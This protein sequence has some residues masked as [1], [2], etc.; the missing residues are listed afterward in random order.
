MHLNLLQDIQM[1]LRNTFQLTY[2]T[3]PCASSQGKRPKEQNSEWVFLS[4]PIVNLLIAFFSVLD[5]WCLHTNPTLH[6]LSFKNLEISN[7]DT[8]V[9]FCK[10]RHTLSC[11]HTVSILCWISSTGG[12]KTLVWN[13]Q[14]TG[15]FW[16]LFSRYFMLKSS[17]QH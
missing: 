5:K 1:N 11:S 10:K 7:G 4:I 3:T 16:N 15:P 2:K 6:K 14:P 8:K 12:A 17:Q 9:M 13:M